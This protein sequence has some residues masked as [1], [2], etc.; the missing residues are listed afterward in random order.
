M[1]DEVLSFTIELNDNGTYK[2][3]DRLSTGQK[4]NAILPILLLDSDR[5]LIIDQPE[6]NLDNGCI[7]DTIVASIQAVKGRRQLVFAT[8]NPNIPVLG[9]AEAMLVMK[10]DGANGSV[11]RTGNVDEC[12]KEIIDLLEGGKEAFEQRMTRYKYRNAK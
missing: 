11:Q 2:P 5:P 3:T 8:H 4:C 7:H 6:D 12:K 1:S 9:D 10:S